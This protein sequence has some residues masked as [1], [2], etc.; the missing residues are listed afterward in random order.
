[1]TALTRDEW[2]ARIVATTTE[3]AWQAQVLAI[4]RL[5]GWLVYHP[6]DSRR[7]VPGFPDLTLV[8]GPRLMFVE[9]KTQKGRVTT[10]QQK[11]LDALGSASVEVYVWRPADHDEVVATLTRDGDTTRSWWKP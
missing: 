5:A 7:S 1:M 4:A 8:R 6:F 3:K 10:D 2:N 9:L 11:W